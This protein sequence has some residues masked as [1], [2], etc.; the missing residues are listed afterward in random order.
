[1]RILTWVKPTWNWMH[2]WNYFWA[3]LPIINDAPGNLTFLMLA[4]LHSL[5]TVH[6]WQTLEDYKKRVLCEYFAILWENS[7]IIV[8][9]QSRLYRH[10]DITWI[11]CSVTPYSLMLRAHAFKDSKTKNIDINM[12]IFNYPILM[13]ADILNFDTDYVPVWK[14]QKQH[15]EFTRDIAQN[16]NNTYWVDFFKL[17]EAK[18]SST[19]W[20]IPWTDWRK[21]SKSYDNHI[22][23]FDPED[24]IYRKVMSIVTDT[25]TLE[26]PKNPDTCNVFALIKLFA[27]EEKQDEIRKKYLEWN[28]WYWSAKNE[29]LMLILSY[30]RDARERYNIYINNFSLIQEKVDRWNQFASRIVMEKYN[31]IIKLVWL[32]DIQ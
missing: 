18:I 28:Y 9:E 14:D 20:I 19:L 27:S 8:F 16:F 11:L 24:E 3:V 30:F 13:A 7:D 25:K 15:I 31:E 2:I 1:M 22:W 32:S 29:L 12:A 21:M 17:P 26:E 10:V 5:T 6:N 4:D 23:I